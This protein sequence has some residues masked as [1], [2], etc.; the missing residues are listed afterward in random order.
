MTGAVRQVALQR[1]ASCGAV[2]YP[3]RASCVRCLSD[4][5]AWDAADHVAGALL[6]LTVLH[7][8]NEPRFRLHLPLTVGLVQLDAG[9]VAVCFVVGAHV[10]GDRMTVRA[11]L[12]EVGHPVL[13]AA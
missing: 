13:E 1:C 6:A 9:P 11:R 10:I 7:H 3:P 8:S 4:R 12:D 2:Q 5:L